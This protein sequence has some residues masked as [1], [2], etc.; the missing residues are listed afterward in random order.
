MAIAD[1]HVSGNVSGTWTVEAMP[2]IVDDDCSVPAGASLTI[3]AG[4]EIRFTRV[5]PSDPLELAVY[6]VL[7]SVGT[8][9]NPILFKPHAE[10]VNPG[11]WDGIKFL[12]AEASQSQLSHSKLSYSI[13]GIT[14]QNSSP[15]ISHCEIY[16]SSSDG[17]YIDDYSSPTICYN[18][19]RNNQAKG[20]SV[21]DYAAPN[22]Y[23]NTIVSNTSNGIYYTDYTAGMAYNNI[24]WGN[25]SYGIRSNS[26]CSPALTYN[27]AYNN[28]G[29]NYYGCSG[30]IG[31]ISADPAFV[32]TG[33]GNYSL[34][35]WS[36]CIDAGDPNSPPDPD[37]TRADMGA[38][39]FYQA[40]AVP[41][42]TSTPDTTAITSFSYV[43][44]V[45]AFGVPIPTYTLTQFPIGMTIEST[46]G[47]IQWLPNI[48]QVGTFPVMVRATNSLGFCDQ[49]YNI[50]TELNQ[51]PE[52]ISFTPAQIDTVDYGEAVE[53]SI[54]AEEPNGQPMFYSWYLDNASLGISLASA[55]IS[56]NSVGEHIV[57]VV[58]TDGILSDS[59]LWAPFVPGTEI[60]GEMSG[61]L[62]AAGNP[63]YM[64]EDITVLAGATLT[65]QAGTQIHINRP[66][67]TNPLAILV[68][69]KLEIG[70]TE[71]EPV[72]LTPQ[73]A[74][75][76]LN[77]WLG[78]DFKDNANSTSY[79][80]Y[81]EVDH[82]EEG[83]KIRNCSPAISYNDIRLCS[84][85][86]ISSINLGSPSIH[87]NSV[88]QVTGKGIYLYTGTA[89]VYNNTIVSTTGTGIEMS[90]T[91][92][93][94]EVYNN[95]SCWNTQY[96]IKLLTGAAALVDYNDGYGNAV[97]NYSGVSM[98]AGGISANPELT[99]YIM[100]NFTL[101]ANS[102]CIDAGDPYAPLDPDG[103]FADMGRFVYLQNPALP[104]FLSMPD[105]VNIAGF[106]FYYAP[107]VNGVPWPGFSLV[108]G[109]A[110]MTVDPLFG[111]INYLASP[112]T[113]G[114]YTVDLLAQNTQ[115]PTHQIW[116]LHINLN[117]APLIPDYWPMGLDTAEF[118]EEIDFGV[119][120]VDPDSHALD[121][122]WK[123]NGTVIAMGVSEVT[124]LSEAFGSNAVEVIVTDGVDS[125]LHNWNYWINGTMVNGEISG[126]WSM[127][128]S[129]YLAMNNLTVAVDDSLIIEPGV[130]VLMAGDYMFTV[131]GY[132][133]ALGTYNNIIE[134][135]SADLN[136]VPD[137][138]DGIYIE[139]LSN[140]NSRLSYVDVRHAHN[141][142]RANYS[143]PTIDHC[144]AA[145]CGMFGIYLDHSASE[146]Y[147][148]TLTHNQQGGVYCNTANAVIN[149]SI[150]AF[151]QDYGIHSIDS[152]PVLSYN[153]VYSQTSNYSGCTQG[154]GSLTTN[155]LFQSAVDFHLTEMS[156]CINVGDPNRPNDPD[157]TRSDMGAYY[158][159][160]LG[161]SEEPL[162]VQIPT[163]YRLKEA[164]PNPFNAQ[165]T[166]EYWLPEKSRVELKMYS[167]LGSEVTTLVEGG[168]DA[169]YYSAVWNADGVS[170]GLYFCV[171]EAKN[172]TGGK[173]KAVN[174]LVLVK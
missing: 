11:H 2:Y 160:S 90:L 42:I 85:R 88:W 115:G 68:Y 41:V 127:A 71:A 137:D 34:N 161:V 82:A 69:G 28:T 156:P 174:K 113:T 56:F 86:G 58:V 38:F 149:N 48:T 109:P 67:P 91:A 72:I 37:G 5:S 19:I 52:I 111:T 170:S 46:T 92:A 73:A 152:N 57:K 129:P 143:N 122:T 142:I 51:A 140:D 47:L 147:N 106:S 40:P 63:Y 29:G 21:D 107:D 54:L 44:N 117:Q 17:L 1:T 121:Y 155:P 134:F 153:D 150:V 8:E 12:T 89:Q 124:I 76:A 114:N 84:Y 123:L 7:N 18:L 119:F 20:I 163:E 3:E 96:G 164:Y 77:H 128:G 103:T 145:Y 133:E 66:S 157:G 15:T 116:T 74:S 100:G 61:I 53:F 87:H 27:D 138:W 26:T 171:L 97:G 78:I 165:A 104:E 169:G 6:G 13:D 112:S 159:S 32:S 64:T 83:I 99:D 23:H 9:L 146:I 50:E 125:T 70:G 139:A 168:Q 135:N 108:S 93:G 39:Y 45:D 4:V 102:P 120:A 154:W 33:T 98:G 62:A 31:S 141:G 151:N 158:Y 148:V 130:T 110:G 60:E 22:I 167:L 80:T 81:C 132:I 59:L 10:P 79:V 95:I 118:H 55:I 166:I 101:Q 65:I 131:Q 105:T 94:T 25:S 162:I 14:V 173:F 136:P 24:V 36:P 35:S 172:A 49:S 75:P 144:T 43:Y 126:V 30:G 16:L